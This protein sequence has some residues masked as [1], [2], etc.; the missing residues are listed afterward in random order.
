[1]RDYGVTDSILQLSSAEAPMESITN[2]SKTVSAIQ[3]GGSVGTNISIEIEN[4]KTK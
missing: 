2:I 3:E 4:T 1:M